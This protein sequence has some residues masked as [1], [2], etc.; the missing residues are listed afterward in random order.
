MLPVRNTLPLS[1]CCAFACRPMTGAIGKTL[2]FGH[3]C[4]ITC[5]ATA[6]RPDTKNITIIFN[7]THHLRNGRSSSASLPGSAC[8]T[9]TRGGK[10]C[11]CLLQDLVGLAQFTVLALQRFE[12]R[13]L[14][15]GQTAAHPGITFQFLAPSPQA[16]RR[17]AKLGRNRPV[18]RVP[19][20]Q[21]IP[22][23]I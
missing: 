14:I 6:D 22:R 8:L 7:E 19:R 21:M 16:V 12:S 20:L 4:A 18:G 10:I 2:P 9:C 23:I 1:E 17:T 5:R 11:R 3:C 15:A 13:F